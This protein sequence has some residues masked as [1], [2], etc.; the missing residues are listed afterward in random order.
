MPFPSLTEAPT[1]PT[2][3]MS[4][5]EFIAAADAFVAW[6]AVF[7]DEVTEWAEY[8]ATLAASLGVSSADA[9]LQA[10]AGLASAADKLGYFTG[11]GTM[12][13]TDFTSVARTLVSQS[14]QALMRTTG[15]GMSANG[16]SLVSAAD[17]S[18]MRTLLG[19]VIGTNVQAHSS[20]LNTFAGIAPSANVQSLLG[21]ADY[22]AIRTLLGLVIGTNVQS[23]LT[24]TTNA[25]G[26]AIGI[27]IG[28]TTYYV[29]W[30]RIS[31]GANTTATITF[32]V[33]FTTA[34][35]VTVVGSG[36][37]SAATTS[38]TSN[39]PGIKGS[40]TTTTATVHSADA[41]TTN[42][43]HWIAIGY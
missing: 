34:S 26:N 25:N 43:F 4:N 11:S 31:V 13:L 36:V 30:G 21:A 1:A 37:A 40:P 8:C 18:A 5:D 16:S 28:A 39:Y 10:F 22:S 2:R 41:N 9:E 35:S 24:F 42:P 6:M 33:A 23:V 27:T 19:L 32:P 15:L 38:D 29:Q 17:Y 14:T 7:R 12:S 20:N 3:S